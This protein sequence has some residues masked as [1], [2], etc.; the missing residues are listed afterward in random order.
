MSTPSIIIGNPIKVSE[1]P[2]VTTG[3]A[4]D[5]VVLESEIAGTRKIAALKFSGVTV[6]SAPTWTGLHIFNNRVAMG[7]GYEANAQLTL[8][9]DQLAG[10]TWV[11]LRF[12][13]VPLPVLVTSPVPGGVETDGT[14]LFFTTAAAVRFKLSKV[15]AAG[16]EVPTPDSLPGIIRAKLLSLSSAELILLLIGKGLLKAEDVLKIP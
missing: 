7:I 5:F 8:G 1:L 11:P 15:A 3:L 12:A 6:D 9:V 10:L 4:D 13:T 16:F 14:D 2:E